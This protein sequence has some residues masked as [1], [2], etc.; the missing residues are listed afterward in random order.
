MDLI[1]KETDPRYKNLDK[2]LSYNLSELSYCDGGKSWYYYIPKELV[3]IED[4]RVKF[5]PRDKELSWDNYL[6]KNVVKWIEYYCNISVEDYFCLFSLHINDRDLRPKC[7]YGCGTYLPFKSISQGYGRMGN[8]DPTSKHYCCNECQRLAH[9]KANKESLNSY[10]PRIKRLRTMFLS[11]GNPDDPC[12]FYVTNTS[13]N[14]FKFG[15]TE[16]IEGRIHSIRYA[17]IKYLNP[18]VIFRGTRLQ[19]ANLEAWIKIDFKG[20]EYLDSSKGFFDSFRKPRI[21]YNVN[22]FEYDQLD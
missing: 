1:I 17:G 9:E 6:S 22:P 14:K 18:R 15:V 20:E 3:L 16:N 13:D 8:W 4:D 12:E 7:D 2:I 11:Y 21:D 10:L 19:V 5:N